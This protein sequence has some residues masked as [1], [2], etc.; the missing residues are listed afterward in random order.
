[1][2]TEIV[3]KIG[4]KPLSFNPFPPILDGRA[5]DKI[6]EDIKALYRSVAAQLKGKVWSILPATRYMD[7]QRNGNRSRYSLTEDF[8]Q[9]TRSSLCSDR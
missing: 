9:K 4:N 5:W 7:L 1:M 6:D 3:D 8:Q 2:L